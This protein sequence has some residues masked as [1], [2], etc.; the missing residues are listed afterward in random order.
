MG[1]R[2]IKRMKRAR[3][4]GVDTPEFG[5]ALKAYRRMAPVASGMLAVIVF[6]IVFKPGA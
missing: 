4:R 6:L 5:L 1:T 3:E 2:E